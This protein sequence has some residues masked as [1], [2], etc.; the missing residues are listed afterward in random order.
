MTILIKAY[1]NL[2][3]RLNG[4]SFEK[5]VPYTNRIQSTKVN[6]V[7]DILNSLEVDVGEISH[8][9]INNKYSGPGSKVKDGDRIG[10]FPRS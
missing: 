1:G 10:I 8:V 6:S 5:G 9:F 3:D 2:G 7:I 4:H